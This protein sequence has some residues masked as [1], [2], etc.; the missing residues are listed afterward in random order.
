MY[1]RKSPRDF[2]SQRK[3]WQLVTSLLA[4]PH[5]AV[6]GR[7][8]LALDHL[9]QRRNLT[10]PTTSF[11]RILLLRR[12][13]GYVCAPNYS[14]V[15]LGNPFVELGGKVG[16]RTKAISDINYINPLISQHLYPSTPRTFINRGSYK[17]KTLVSPTRSK[18]V[19]K[20]NGRRG[21]CLSTLFTGGTLGYDLKIGGFAVLQ[22]GREAKEVEVG[23]RLD[24]LDDGF[25]P[26]RLKTFEERTWNASICAIIAMNSAR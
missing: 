5:L 18:S 1:K 6:Q 11:P 25:A 10:D 19:L 24:E 22:A 9:T 2:H 21:T 15:N 20:S 8:L 13:V 23:S 14:I 17:F 4:H 26:K 3:R 7:T 12:L 16:V